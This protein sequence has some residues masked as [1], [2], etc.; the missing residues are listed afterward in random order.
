M[1]I[2]LGIIFCVLA[3]TLLSGCGDRIEPKKLSVV[4]SIIYDVS[5]N[6]MYKVT[7]EFLN[8][9]KS[10][11]S[12]DSGGGKSPTLTSIGESESLRG[13]LSNLALSIEKHV[14]G[15]H[16]KARFL[17]ENFAGNDMSQF[18]DY[19]LRDHLTD[20][21]PLLVVIRGDE[22]EKIYSCMIGMS[23]MV[24]NYIDD[25]SANQKSNNSK[26]VIVTTLDFIK[27]L[28]NDGK[29]PVAGLVDMVECEA[30]PSGNVKSDSSD[31]GEKEK[32]FRIKYEGL[33][34]FK[35]GKLVG[36]MDGVE[37]RAYNFITGNIG[38][39]F[40]AIPSGAGH[41]VL[42]IRDVK[43]E[44]KASL[45]GEKFDLSVI[46]KGNLLVVEEAG[47][48]DPTNPEAI[49]SIEQSV[50]TQLEEEIT[51]AIEKAQK[52]F[53]SDIFGFGKLVHMK[54]SEKWKEIS[55]D[56]NNYF[57]EATID[58]SVDTTVKR[59]GEIKKPFAVED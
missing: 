23:E 5:E 16:N 28:Y 42:E 18:F 13:A 6:G 14:F 21:T 17:S 12:E 25:L 7:A 48:S 56:W 49:K 34:A 47:N 37:A 19:L 38:T 26:G 30:K 22:P 46:I 32:N 53:K 9:S 45:S 3:M 11:N 8:P 29:E 43:P 35:D 20:E 55:R 15:G 4:N 52:E 1:R 2:R 39:A 27:D 57:S 36:F 10:E 54:H 31:M 24:G 33:A 41:T 40:A 50:N 51:A 58:V 44:L 59:T